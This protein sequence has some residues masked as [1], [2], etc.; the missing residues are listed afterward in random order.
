MFHWIDS[1]IQVHALYYP[2]ALLLLAL[3]QHELRQAGLTLS[4]DRAI[5]H[6]Q[7][8]Q[9]ALILYTNDRADRVLS[10]MDPAQTEPADALSLEEPARRLGTTALSIK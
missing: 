9:E 1:K 6:L 2:F 10:Q 7:D 5:H 3:V 4:I 8:I